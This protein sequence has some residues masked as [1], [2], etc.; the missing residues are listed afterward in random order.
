MPFPCFAAEVLR[1]A[2][3]TL[4]QLHDA[5]PGMVHGDYGPQNL[6]LDTAAWEVSAVLDW[7][8]AHDGDP[9]EDLAWAEWIVRMHHP[10]AAGAIPVLFESYRWRPTWSVRRSAM[11]KR[12][13]ELPAPRHPG[14]SGDVAISARDHSGLD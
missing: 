6:L 14:C 3:R 8:F 2:G 13:V 1:A 9:V 12:C 7:E 5:V 10:G 4:R 11:L